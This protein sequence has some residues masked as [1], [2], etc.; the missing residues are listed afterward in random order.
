MK[1]EARV[2]EQLKELKKQG[3]P[4][5]SAEE[6]EAYMANKSINEV[7][8]SSRLKMEVQY[9]RDTSLSLPKSSAVF[10]IMK[11]K[12][13]SGSRQ[14]SALEFSENLTKLL[15]KKKGACGKTV[16]ISNFMSYV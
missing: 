13:P 15:D 9:A 11:K 2:L 7:Q 6:V 1:V 4:F 14:L 5:T 10:R 16:S 3:G 8:K 12:E